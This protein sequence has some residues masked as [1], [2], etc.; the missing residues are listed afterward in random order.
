MKSIP[1][2][3]PIFYPILSSILSYPLSS[4]L[5]YL[6]L[7]QDGSVKEGKAYCIQNIRAHPNIVWKKITDLPNYPKMVK[8]VKEVQTYATSYPTI[9]KRMSKLVSYE[10]KDRMKLGLGP[11][12]LFNIEYYLHHKMDPNKKLI[13]WTL[14]YDR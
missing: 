2:F 8:E 11:G 13:T 10:T 7:V 5:S 6:I 12:G 14:D 3:Y 9:D 1:I 4:I